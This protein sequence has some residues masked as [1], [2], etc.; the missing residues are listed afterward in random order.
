MS[1]RSTKQTASCVTRQTAVG[2][3]R[4][5]KLWER[6]IL[7]PVKCRKKL[8]RSSPKS[9]AKARAK[10]LLSERSSRPTTSNNSF[11]TS[12]RC[13]RRSDRRQDALL[14]SQEHGA[15]ANFAKCLYWETSM[16]ECTGDP[17]SSTH[18]PAVFSSPLEGRRSF[19]GALLGVVSVFVGGLLCVPLIR[20][21]LHP[22]LRSTTP[23]AWCDVG[24]VD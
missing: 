13:R 3:L 5:E 16:C 8:M 24:T 11:P 18:K 1:P 2:A 7:R 6:R 23:V 20:L 14:G 19:L 4:P 17:G 10:C 9:S 12:E 15:A 21:V 22:L